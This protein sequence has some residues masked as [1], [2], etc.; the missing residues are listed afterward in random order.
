MAQSVTRTTLKCAASALAISLIALTAHA[1]PSMAKSA[2]AAAEDPSNPVDAGTTEVV[3]TGSRIR[4]DP[5]KHGA[6]V[7]HVDAADIARTGLT[8]IAD[9][10]QKLPGSTGGI[11]SRNNK[12]GNNGN[13][14]DG[15]G[16]GAGSAEIDIRYL[17]SRRTLV[18]VDG[19]RYINGAAASGVP[20]A[21]DLNSIPEGMIERVEVLRDGASAIY[22][23]DAIAG[24][25]NIITKKRQDGFRISAQAGRYDESDGATQ[26]YD[27]SYGKSFDDGGAFIAGL[28]YA[29][30]DPIFKGDRSLYAYPTPG[31]TACDSSCSS[32]TPLGRFIVQN[33]VSGESLN[34]TLKNPVLTGTA[35]SIDLNDPTGDS[36]DFKAFTTADRFNFSPYNYILTPNRRLGAFVTYTRPLGENTHFTLKTLYNERK[37][38]NQ[39]AP[40]PLFVG[41]DAG[42]GNLLD[43]ISIDATNPYNPF[44][45]TLDAGGTGGAGSNYAFIARRVVEIGPRHFDQDVKTFYANAGL[46][47]QVEAFGKTWFWDSN[48]V[49]ATNKAEQTMSANVNA[50]KLAKALGPVADCTGDCVPFNIFG[51]VGSITQDMINYVVFKQHDSSEQ[52]MV[53]VSANITGTLMELPA[54]PLGV[55]VGYEGRRLSGRFDP[56]PVVAAGYGSDIPAQPARGAY[57]VNEVYGEIN[58]P[59]LKDLPGAQ[60]L[61]TSFAVRYFDYSTSGSDS[62][63]KAGLSWKPVKDLR[64][65]ATYA[66]GFRAPSIGELYGAPSRYDAGLNDP[67]SDFNNSG[68]SQTVIDHCITLGVPAN[69]S[70]VQ[71]G[72]QLGVLTGGSKT[73][74]P[75]TSKSYVAGFAYAPGWASDRAWSKSLSLEADY[76]SITVDN[77]IASPSADVLINT[78]VDTLDSVACGAITRSVTGQITQIRGTLQNIA[79]IESAGIDLS[80]AYQ[81]PPTPLGDFGVLLTANFLGE[82][83]VKTPSATGVTTVA[84]KGTETGE[85]AYP[86]QK[87]NLTVTWQKDNLFASLTG[88]YIGDVI[89]TAADDN[90]MSSVVF[91]DLQFGWAP[92]RFNGKYEITAGVNNLFDKTPPICLSCGGYDPST[93]DIIG[94]FSYI[95]L[96]YR[97]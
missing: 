75:E 82:Y 31:A 35:P 55:A 59:I 24:V 16:V 96:T 94:Q 64:L 9:V 13:P 22:G 8:S 88:R 78:C 28:S 71:S 83:S 10:L 26:F 66:E 15:G 81:A 4:T 90:R 70:Y 14:P 79:S 49:F 11:N 62:T 95:R 32:A 85:Q 84:Y 23:S 56:D 86:K 89:E 61:E 3:V 93:Y 1:D 60:L 41:P 67:C 42:N 47:G 73:L 20:A 27:A 36:S 63:M 77:A 69:G 48:V 74:S 46:D 18:L 21:V 65:R 58:V 53:D 54:G 2:P 57:T 91:T 87:T 39:A 29:R 5:L 12:S 33:E 6:P 34:L 19:Q 52:G 50:F 38:S 40:L 25:V 37:S 51:G 76:Y 43:T 72:G 7:T 92:K 97:Q 17:G 30:Q 68:V 80:L 44:G 45:Y